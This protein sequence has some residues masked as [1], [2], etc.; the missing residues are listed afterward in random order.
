VSGGDPY[1]Y[2]DAP[3]VLK[4]KFGIKNAKR[5]EK[6]ERRRVMQR[7]EEGLPKGNFD[8]DHLCAIHRHLFQD[9]Y[10]WA[11]EIR[12]V[13]IARG[14]HQFMFGS[15]IVTG[16]QDVHNRL[17]TKNFLKDLD[18]AAFAREAAQIIGDLNYVHPFREG[19]GRAQV[20]YLKQLAANAGHPIDLSRLKKAQWIEASKAAHDA[21]YDLM[22]IA[23]ESALT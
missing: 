17:R 16:M 23:I 5:L 12:T 20:Q 18:A 2:A 6:A 14:K 7:L 10:E 13:E 22:R 19:N 3:G 21:N 15:Y 11:G 1:V 9:V 4:N 8:L